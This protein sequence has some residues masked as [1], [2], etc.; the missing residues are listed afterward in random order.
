MKKKELLQENEMLTE[1]AQ[2]LGDSLIEAIKKIQELR[3]LA[4]SQNKLIASQNKLI[5]KLRSELNPQEASK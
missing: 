2:Q 3:S 4:E 1:L 5:R